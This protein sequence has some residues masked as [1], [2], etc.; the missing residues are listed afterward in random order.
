MKSHIH[1]MGYGF[2]SHIVKVKL[3]TADRQI[4]N[5]ISFTSHIVKVKPMNE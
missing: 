5:I 3:F 2:T 4:P 1:K